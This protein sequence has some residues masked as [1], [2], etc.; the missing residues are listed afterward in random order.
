MRLPACFP[1]LAPVRADCRKISLSRQISSLASC[2]TTISGICGAF[3]SAVLV[4]HVA[5][6]GSLD[7]AAVNAPLS[8]GI[9]QAAP[10]SVVRR[11]DAAFTTA[12]A[13][14]GLREETD[15][16]LSPAALRVSQIANRNGDSHFVM[17]DKVHGKIMVFENGKPTFSRSALTGE[18]L[19]DLLPPDA[20][21][22]PLSQQ[23]GVKYKVT[24]AGRF[25][26]TRA[27]DEVL[28]DT[29]DINELEGMDWRIAIHRV[30]LGIR[31]QHRDARLRSAN[32]QDKHVTEGC[33]DV[34][35]DTIVQLFRHLPNSNKI[36]IYI[37]PID[38]SLIA[39]LF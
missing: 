2:P 6:A 31:S 5:C 4:C 7:I 8:D 36:A 18:S 20:R 1:C 15:L 35:P 34:D 12:A 25:T 21:E 29:F 27:H 33:I 26:L 13:D 37:L 28:G 14:A 3:V 39:T 17:V 32:D 30:W 38:E 16:V 11:Q 23:I 19:A 9:H 22:K 10:S 24:P